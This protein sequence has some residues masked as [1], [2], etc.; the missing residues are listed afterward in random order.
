MTDTQSVAR[1]RAFAHD[2]AESAWLY[3]HL[4]ALERDPQVAAIYQHLADVEERHR[5]I[6][7]SQGS[8]DEAALS[9]YHPSWRAH[10][11]LWLAQRMG[12]ATVLPMMMAQEGTA[13][14][15]YATD[16][17]AVAAGLPAEERSHARVFRAISATQRGTVGGPLLAQ[18]EGRH[19]ATGGNALRAAVLGAS[20]GLT[21]NMSLVM[22]VAG[23][24]LA[25]HTILLTGLAGLLAGGLSMAIGEWL[26]VQSA[27]DLYERQIAI[28]RA[29][30]AQSPADEQEELA[31]IYQ[32]KGIDA[33]T[34]TRLAAQMM[35]DPAVALDTLTREELGI[36]PQELGGSAWTAAI[37]SFLLFSA[38][39]LVPVLPF[40]FGGGTTIV[41]ISLLLSIIGLFV[42]GIGVSL[43]TGISLFK[44]GG[45]QVALGLMAALIT[46]S[47]GKVIGGRLG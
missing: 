20:D 8:P 4:A 13:A 31:L 30:I 29:E 27:R 14:Q 39:A 26:S 33:P 2:E 43:T 15:G 38:G 44:A 40:F 34:A 5:T 42:I 45:R 16:P 9:H 36:D 24:T 32:S 22:G 46:F 17:V 12:P 28:E 6:W 7:V 10:A 3:Q 1:Y 18:L 21:S 19:R 37:T 35:R 41:V 11:L 47:L 25:A 23:A